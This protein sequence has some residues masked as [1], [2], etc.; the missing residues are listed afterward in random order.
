MYARLDPTAS[1]RLLAAEFSKRGYKT[2]E[3]VL[4]K[5]R[6]F[7]AVSPQGKKWLTPIAHISYPM[8]SKFTGHISIQKDFAYRMVGEAGVPIPYTYTLHPGEV[9]PLS[10]SQELFASCGKLVVK[11][12]DSTLSRGVTLNATTVDELQ[13]AIADA[14]KSAANG[15]VLV[16]QQVS[17]EE[18][19]FIYLDGTVTAALLRETPKLIGD[20]RSTLQELLDRE[21]EKRAALSGVMVPYPALTANMIS[22]AIDLSRAPEVGEV[23]ELS[24]STMIKGGASVYNVLEEMNKS[25]VRL[26]RQAADAVGMKFIVVDIMVQDYTKPFDGTNAYFNEFNT[27]PVLKLCY[28][29]RDGRQCD[30]VPLLVDAIDKR[31]HL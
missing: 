15:K 20:G 17:G 2:R 18:I 11:P 13:R 19:R 12:T 1:Y 10:T 23:V 26:A 6:V 7:E 9:I 21:N 27:A 25:Y 14:R 16:Q 5:T 28:S 8:Q 3:F 31:I 22:D 29:C 24:R 30:I 4:A